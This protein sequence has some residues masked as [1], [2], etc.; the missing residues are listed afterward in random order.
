M[1]WP[2]VDKYER[3]RGA[4]VVD[5]GILAK[6]GVVWEW[7]VDLKFLFERFLARRAAGCALLLDRVDT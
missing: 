6:L 2:T 1:L 5:G 7:F 4:S 3:R